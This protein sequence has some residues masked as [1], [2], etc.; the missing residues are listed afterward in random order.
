MKFKGN[1]TIDA[2]GLIVAPGF[3]DTH[4]HRT[5]P[6]GYKLA[7][8]DGVSTAMDLEADAYG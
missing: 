3:I 8:R 4:F 6:I 2:I 7:L 5:R 1:E